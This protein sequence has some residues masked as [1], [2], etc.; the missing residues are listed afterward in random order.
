MAALAVGNI[1]NADLASVAS[2]VDVAVVA[3][4][5]G[6]VVFIV[7]AVL[8]QGN[9][10]T[11]SLL[12]GI[13]YVGTKSELSG[14]HNDAIMM[15][16][17]IATHVGCRTYRYRVLLLSADRDHPRTRTLVHCLRLA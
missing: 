12:I 10:N 14:C 16:E 5:I 3:V 13:N 1:F 8:E 7:F 4:D 6:D 11:R 15:K 9:G 17:Y 2:V